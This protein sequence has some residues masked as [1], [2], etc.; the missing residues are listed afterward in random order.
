[1]VENDPKLSHGVIVARAVTCP[2]DGLVPVRILNPQECSIELKK[3][4]ELAK[5]DHIEQDSILNVSVT[6]AKNLQ[7]RT[8][9]CGIW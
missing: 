4:T 7:L 3:G 6:K 9:C 5:M 8:S 1:M 2:S